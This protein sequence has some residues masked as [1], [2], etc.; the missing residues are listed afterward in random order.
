MPDRDPKRSEHVRAR[1]SPANGQSSNQSGFGRR[2][3]AE[4]L[5]ERSAV[6]EDTLTRVFVSKRRSPKAISEVKH[7]AE[8]SLPRPR[9]DHVMPK[10]EGPDDDATN[11]R[12]LYPSPVGSREPSIES[13]TSQE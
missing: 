9:G 4:L 1:T 7:R 2:L 6:G 11:P 5:G 3:R 10:G 13:S 8:N 12:P